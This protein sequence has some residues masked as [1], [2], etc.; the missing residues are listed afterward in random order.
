MIKLV[1]AYL[2]SIIRSS[3]KCIQKKVYFMKR[4]PLYSEYS[5]RK[6]GCPQLKELNMVL[7]II[8]NSVITVVR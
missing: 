5:K 6:M 1:S 2:Y 3:Y 7:A 8:P 4:P